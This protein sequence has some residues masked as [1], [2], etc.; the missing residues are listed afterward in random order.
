MR[1]LNPRSRGLLLGA[2]VAAIGAA[3][4]NAMAVGDVAPAKSGGD[5]IVGS[6][7]PNG[8]FTEGTGGDV[9]LFLR[10]R[11]RSNGLPLDVVG[12]TYTVLSGTA[13]STSVS[14]WSFDFQ[15]TPRMS[16][17]IAG[18]NYHMTLELDTDPSNAADYVTVSLPVFDADSDPAN[19]WDDGDGLFATDT[20]VNG[21]APTATP[22][23]DPSWNYVYSQSWRPD[24]G[25]LAGSILPVGQ[26]DIRL[27]V[28]RDG[29]PTGAPIATSAIVV[30][31]IDAAQTGLTLD[32]QDSCLTTGE[33]LVVEVNMNN[34]QSTIVGGQFFL[35]YDDTQLD[36]VGGVP[37]D[38]PFDTE[39]L[40]SE[41][42]AG[43]INYAVGITPGGSGTTDNVTMARL[44]FDVI[45]SDFC[46]EDAL[47]AFRSNVPPTRLTESGGADVSPTLADLNPVT[48]DNMA[49]VVTAPADITVNA[50]AGL[51]TA[52]LMHNEPFDTPV[53]L[54]ASQ[55]PDC[56]YTDRYAPAAF[57]QA[58]FDGDNRLKH[59]ISAA[60]SAANRPPS[61]SSGFY[62][63][64]GRKYDVDIPT[65][66]KISIDMYIDS[67]WMSQ[68][69]RADLWGTTFDAGGNIS[70]FPIFGFITN[71]PADP[72]NTSPTSPD[73]R[74]RFFT[75]DT[76]QDTSNGLTAGWLEFAP[77]VGFS[78]DR[79]YTF[80]IELTAGAYIGR[81]I[82]D[83]DTVLLTV[84]DTVTFGSIRYGNIIVQAFNFGEDY[85]VYWDNVLLG[86][87]GPIVT[88]DCDLAS[89]EFSRSDNPLLGIDD[90]FPTG[91]TTLTWTATDAC[92]NTSSDSSTVTVNAFN[93]LDVAVELEAT[94]DPGPFDRC[95]TFELDPVGA[96][97]L[98]IVSETLTFTG[99]VA[100][101]SIDVPCGD[102]EC[103]TARDTLHTLRSTDNDDFGISGANYVANF[104]TSGDGD[105]LRGGNLN[106]DDFVD[107]LDFG[108]FI[109]MFGMS[110][111]ADT[112]CGFVGPH[113]DISGD[114]VV[115]T[116]DFTSIQIN[117]LA[118]NELRCDGS[119][120]IAPDGGPALAQ[121]GRRVSRSNEALTSI[122]VEEL[123]RR[124]MADLAQADLTGDGVLD[125]EDVV[126]FM[127][128]ARPDRMA[129]VN[130]DGVVDY[131]DA[132][133]L[134][135]YI[136]T[137]DERYDMDGDGTVT[138][139]DLRFI[140]DR[141]GMMV[142]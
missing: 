110:P 82:D 46:F 70:G 67:G 51:C 44:T 53:P 25:F 123:E 65:G 119:L 73:P 60:D 120:L 28:T 66:N 88:E 137:T 76:D 33:Q 41:P 23:D 93:T 56:W 10:A 122:T 5:M 61:F 142:G 131:T 132:K 101:G 1:S 16:D 54:C 69:R 100:S 102:Y 133:L 12:S 21:A 127:G 115:G 109:G 38:A 72:F 128:G 81:L 97:P 141:F 112:P 75:Q 135:D 104:T 45:G 134:V 85:D 103:I 139:A 42:A 49:P 96:G 47:V 40:D 98:V 95:I 50:D 136:G 3:C 108:V 52:T 99:G 126:A 39:I 77:P 83:T 62:D 48:F 13:P 22:W 26:Y 107:I 37:G 7:I 118:F 113:A 17:V 9:S 74:F 64:Q 105:A 59:S 94:V 106:D 32:A 36:Y 6:G 91:T 121:H 89:V 2:S 79:W 116:G 78:Y 29:D 19:S 30:Q 31:V 14:W 129:D 111:G 15:F 18:T 24:F 43:E 4:S 71:D 20:G 138:A 35:S 80:E 84:V 27:S 92:G 114:G 8:N 124:G 58:F 55:T 117:F 63:T 86:P 130:G 34:A 68:V 11:A 90:P 140:I 125:I 57:E 87:S